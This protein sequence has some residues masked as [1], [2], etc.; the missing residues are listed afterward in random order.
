MRVITC[1]CFALMLA[2][3]TAS[4]QANIVWPEATCE[5]LV[6]AMQK[7]SDELYKDNY[8]QVLASAFVQNRLIRLKD[9]GVVTVEEAESYMKQASEYDN[10]HFVIMMTSDL[11][12]AATQKN[13][14]YER[15]GVHWDIPPQR[16]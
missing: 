12:R 13:C 4:A 7:I 11:G 5:Q 9:G 10:L 15:R 1:A 3:T 2:T 8:A 16:E 14:K 6:S